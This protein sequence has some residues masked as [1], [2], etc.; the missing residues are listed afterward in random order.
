MTTISSVR[1]CWQCNA[2]VA[3]DAP[4]G[5]CPRCLLASRVRASEQRSP[6][7][8]STTTP[9]VP[10]GAPPSPE[11][12]A[13]RFPQL[14]ILELLGQGGMGG[15]YKA[16]QRKLDRLVAVKVLPAEWGKDPAFAER[17]AREA[18][19]LARLTHPH[20]VSVF[21]FGESDGLFYFIM[22]YVDGVNLR[23]ILQER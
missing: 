17:F 11:E 7:R 21:D 9:H 19:A 20:V 4:E 12:L 18:R 2:E 1:R 10:L 5:L 14:E 15:V 22:E 6:V 3:A 13:T 23:A 16:R 8:E